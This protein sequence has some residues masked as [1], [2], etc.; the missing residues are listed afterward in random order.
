MID[1]F[2]RDKPGKSERFDSLED[3]MRHVS[4]VPETKRSTPS[5]FRPITK[6]E[7][8]RATGQINQKETNHE[9]P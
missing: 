4:E 3:A 7:R 2:K 9:T 6:A 5:S 1:P 8:A